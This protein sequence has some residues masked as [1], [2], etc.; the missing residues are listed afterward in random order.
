MWVVGLAIALS[1]AALCVARRLCPRVG[2][3]SMWWVRHGCDSDE[4]KDSCDREVD[5]RIRGGATAKKIFLRASRAPGV[6]GVRLPDLRRRSR[7]EIF[8]ARVSR[9]PCVSG[10]DPRS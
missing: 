2:R 7:S 8:L 1:V 10:H 4:P 3:A 5:F 9:A 6:S